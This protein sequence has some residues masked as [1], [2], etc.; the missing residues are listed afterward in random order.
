MTPS[1][2]IFDAIPDLLAKDPATLSAALPMY[3]RLVIANFVPAL[4][5]DL[6]LLT[7][8]TFTGSADLAVTAGDQAVYYDA[9]SGLLTIEL[10]EPAG[11]F[12]WTCTADPADP[13]TVYGIVVVDNAKTVLIG[14]MLLDPAP[15]ISSAGQG[16]DVGF[17]Q[18][19]FL[20]NNP[21]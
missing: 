9:V 4:D 21:R 8:A 18:F 20:T 5:L 14:S 11:G 15:V 12:H 10:L 7:F 19:S 3:V 16:M 2:V 13:E 17:L 6:T 1:R